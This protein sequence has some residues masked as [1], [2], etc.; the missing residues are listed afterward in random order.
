[1]IFDEDSFPLAAS[2]SL[3]DLDFLCESS[4]TVSTIGTHLTTTGTSTL[5]PRRPAPEIPPGFEPPVGPLPA[6][7]VPPGFLPREATMVAPPTITDSPPPRTWPASPVTYV[8]REVGVG[9]AGTRGPPGAGMSWEVGTEATGT[10]GGLRADLRREEG[11]RAAGTRGG[12]R[13]VLSREVGTTLP[14]PLPRPFVGGQG[15]V[16]PVTPPDN[17]H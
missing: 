16:V 2:P 7:A 12:P 4:P 17:P 15:M 3:T 11:A 6:L 10:H 8:R 9:A 5:T 1:V 14:P 13:V